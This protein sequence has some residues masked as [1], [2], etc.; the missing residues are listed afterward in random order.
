MDSACKDCASETI[1][2]KPVLKSNFKYKSSNDGIIL[3]IHHTVKSDDQVLRM[4]FIVAC[5]NHQNDLFLAVDHRGNVFV[6]DLIN[7]KFWICHDSVKYATAIECVPD[8]NNVIV[9]DKEGLLHVMDYTT[10]SEIMRLKAHHTRVERISFPC[11]SGQVL[12]EPSRSQWRPPS[13][14]SVEVNG[15]SKSSS[16]ISNAGIPKAS[17]RPLFLLATTTEC[18]KLYN[19]RNFV[20][21]HQLNYGALHAMCRIVELRW[22]PRTSDWPPQLIGLG[23][24]GILRIWKCDFELTRK[25]NLQKM[26]DNYLKKFKAETISFSSPYEESI[27]ANGNH[28]QREIEQVIQN[29]TGG[30]R[31]NGILNSIQFDQKGKFLLFNCIDNTFLIVACDAWQIWKIVVLLNL[32]IINFEIVQQPTK[33]KPE[34]SIVAKTA[35]SDLLLMNL[36]DGSSH[37]VRSPESKCYKFCLSGNGKML[38]NLVKSGEILL[39]NLEFYS[40]AVTTNKLHYSATTGTKA[41]GKAPSLVGTSTS[42]LRKRRNEEVSQTNSRGN[43]Y[44]ATSAVS[45]LYY[46]SIPQNPVATAKGV[47]SASSLATNITRSATSLSI[48]RRESKLKVDQRLE[49]IHTKISE[50]LAKNRLLP[51]LK[52]FGEYP[53]KHRLLIWRTLLQLPMNIECL[54]RLLQQ[55]YHP[56]VADYD[57]KFSQYEL[58]TVR[59]MKKVVSGLA[60]WAVVFA[61]CE[62]LPFFVYPFVRLYQNDSLACFETV[63]T[64]LLNQCQLWFEFAPLEPFNYLGLV[65]NVLCELEPKLMSFYRERNISSRVYALTMMQ[66]AFAENFDANQWVRVWDHVLSNETYFMVFF[67]AAYNAAHRSTIMSCASA[68]DVETFFREP[69]L[70]DAGRVLKRTYD[71]LERCPDNIHPQYYMKSFVSLSSGLA[72]SAG[73][74]QNGPLKKHPKLYQCYDPSQLDNRYQEKSSTGTY[75]RFSNFPKHLID[76]K[77]GD[78]DDLKTEQQQLEAK[79]AELEKLELALKNKVTDHLVQQEH[80]NRMR[81]VDKKFAEALANEESRV[82]LQRKLLLLHKKQFRE[83][84]KQAMLQARNVQ[85]QKNASAREYEL[86]NLLKTL[87]QERRRDETEMMFAE[88]NIK[89]REMDA[90]SKQYE[91]I[92]KPKEDQTLDQRYHKAIRQLERQKQKLYEDI[93]QVTQYN[94]EKSSSNASD[95]STWN[96]TQKSKFQRGSEFEVYSAKI[97]SIGEQLESLLQLNKNSMDDLRYSSFE[98]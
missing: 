24:D 59:N 38:A 17:P 12:S 55:G 65:E 46:S 88:E 93:E 21:L 27:S 97:K 60:S 95:S 34:L 94:E 62:F 78:M 72:S 82:E 26:R 56:C 75:S 58:R 6:F 67:I 52:E 1:K 68:N 69:S 76:T 91:T 5:F 19:A 3:N 70:I 43:L 92:I 28:K 80:E 49:E 96:S 30:G 81:E 42:D 16:S 10:G 87:Q 9:G 79:I 39:H 15:G 63:A 77:A 71:M 48:F 83:K 31:G 84:E 29:I 53:H 33:N 50:T 25:L 74:N 66:T 98:D 32:S 7:M 8:I 40:N 37:I 51:I 41:S 90:L 89:L 54:D 11:G 20:E 36:D 44:S 4:R 85:L 86:E 64:I 45:S 35:Q 57:R 47:N 2:I 22:I 18:A 13:T 61:Q 73:A 23:V 14:K